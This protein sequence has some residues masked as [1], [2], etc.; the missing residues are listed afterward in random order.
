MS[1][2][3]DIASAPWSQYFK[4]TPHSIPVGDANDIANTKSYETSKCSCRARGNEP[5]CYSGKCYNYAMQIECID[6]GPTCKNQRIQKNDIANFSVQETDQK[7]YGLFANEQLQADTYVVEYVGEIITLDELLRRRKEISTTKHLYAMEIK[8][9][10][11]IDSTDIGSVSRFINHSCE[12]NCTAEVWVVANRYRVAITTTKIINKGEELSFDYAWEVVDGRPLT[13]CLCGTSSCRG[14]IEIT[15]KGDAETHQY[16]ERTGLWRPFKE[17]LAEAQADWK[18]SRN[19]EISPN[20][21]NLSQEKSSRS[22][23][24]L[25]SHLSADSNGEWLVGKRIS[26]YWEGNMEFFPADVQSY[27]KIQNTHTLYYMIDD[28]V[29][30][31]VIWVQEP[32]NAWKWL[33]ETQEDRAIVKRKVICICV[34]I[35]YGLI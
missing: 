28:S 21:S 33:D 2:N 15:S 16:A 9:N 24:P 7:G 17:A 4:I 18:I 13:K 22:S 12:P 20:S 5:T 23:S 10:T 26:V 35:A 30:N 31:E 32:K 3:I 29:S 27:N 34:F 8:K 11:Y 1:K 6:C 25:I 14:T 19:S